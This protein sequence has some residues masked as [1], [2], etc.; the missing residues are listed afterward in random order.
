MKP[1]IS[2]DRNGAVERG[3]IQSLYHVILEGC[4][5]SFSMLSRQSKPEYLVVLAA[6]SSNGS[7]CL[8]QVQ[9]AKQSKN[10]CHQVAMIVDLIVIAGLIPSAKLLKMKKLNFGA[11]L[12]GFPLKNL[13]PL[14]SFDQVQ[15]RTTVLL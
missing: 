11:I 5:R 6:F 12:Y 13:L 10:V 8:V 15:Q 2:P 9:Q 3:F 1:L 4:C 14:M 7:I